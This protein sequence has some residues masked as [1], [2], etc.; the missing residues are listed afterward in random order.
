MRRAKLRGYF[1]ICMLG[2]GT[3]H[4]GGAQKV[5]DH[6]NKGEGNKE[7]VNIC[8]RFLTFSFNCSLLGLTAGTF[9]TTAPWALFFAGLGAWQ[10]FLFLLALFHLETRKYHLEESHANYSF[11]MSALLFSL[12]WSYAAQDP[13]I[14][15]A[16]G[17]IIISSMHLLL[18]LISWIW[19]KCAFGS[20]FHKVLSCS[21]NPR[22]MLP[23]I[24]RRRDS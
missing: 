15:H 7:L 19:S 13:L 16:V 21:G 11:Y 1:A 14:L 2:L 20:L 18:Y 17:K 22:N 5:L 23:R 6:M 4:W 12:H 24:N 8:V 3:M 10:S 9:H